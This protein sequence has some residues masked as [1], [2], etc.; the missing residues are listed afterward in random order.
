M[1]QKITVVEMR[2]LIEADHNNARASLNH[3]MDEISKVLGRINN[4]HVVFAFYDADNGKLLRK[5]GPFGDATTDLVAAAE[6][7]FTEFN[8]EVEGA[9]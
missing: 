7:E 8:E 5:Y 1:A 9:A 3:A 4:V 6:V 2:L